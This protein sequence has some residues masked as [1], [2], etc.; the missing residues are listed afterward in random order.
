[1]DKFNEL[2]KLGAGDFEHIDGTLIE[3][4]KGT[5]RLLAQ[6]GA[7]KKLQDAGLYHA[8]Y[9]TV[10]FDES[11]V[12][13]HQRGQIAALIGVD[14]E[15]IVYQ[16]C[17]CDRQKFY[18]RIGKS[19]NP[20]FS[21]RFTGEDYVLPDSMF[22]DFCELTVANEL[23]IAIDNPGFIQQYGEGLG[24]LFKKMQPYISQASQIKTEEVLG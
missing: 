23:E 20:E 5:Q 16:Y 17:A 11:L 9:G 6:W 8:A 19:S 1:M 13:T 15:E 18:P 4:L 22:R 12:D 21:N 7:S 2:A 3:H 10:G 24:Q 14:S